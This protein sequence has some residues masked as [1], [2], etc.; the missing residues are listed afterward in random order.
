M[1]QRANKKMLTKRIHKKIKNKR[2]DYNKAIWEYISKNYKNENKN[3]E[4]LCED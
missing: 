4:S 1:A 3:I 2:K